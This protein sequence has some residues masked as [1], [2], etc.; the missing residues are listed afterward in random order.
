[1]TTFTVLGRPAH[2]LRPDAPLRVPGDKSIS[3]RALLLA[4]RAGGTS[5]IAGLSDGDDVR[6]TRDAIEALGAEVTDDASGELVVR[7]GGLRAPDR[8]VDAGNSGTTMRLLA[9]FAAPFRWRTVIEGDASLRRRPM[10][11]VVTPLQAMGARISA[12]EGGL[13][14]LVVEGGD[15]HG[16]EYQLPVASAQVKGAVLLAGLGAEG[17]TVV[18]ERVVTRVHTEELLRTAGADVSIEDGGHTVRVRRSE[19][20]PFELQVLGDPSQAAFWLVAATVVP[21][22]D[23]TVEDV[24]LGPGRDGFLRV[25]QR[26]GAAVRVEG[27]AVR[28]TQAALRSTTIGGDEVPALIDEIPVLAVAAALADGTT[29]FRDAAELRVKESDRI[30]AMAE[31]LSRLGAA[32]EVRADGFAVHG[33]APLRGTTVDAHGDHRVAMALAVA[34]LAA[35]GE[36]TI[37]GWESVAISYPSFEEDLRRCLS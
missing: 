2:G 15:L 7:G 16:I 14:P 3:H 30:A 8:E 27:P 36:T 34:G 24:Y 31:G 20:H 26:M 29:E 19:L 37:T 4:A 35:E 5:R 12:R 1:V 13:P 6:R 32:V 25:L 21:G 11:R 28:A 33:P 22:S 10:D 9:G 17:E 18:R 23:V